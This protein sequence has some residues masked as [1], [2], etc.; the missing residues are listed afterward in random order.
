MITKTLEKKLDDEE[1][2]E[3]QSCEVFKQILEDLNYYNDDT[4]TGNSNQDS[5]QKH[6]DT[7][8]VGEHDQTSIGNGNL[9]SLLR[10]LNQRT[11]LLRKEL[12]I[13]CQIGR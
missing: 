3:E 10:E 6:G 8:T 13:K 5:T 9:S 12:K 1:R 11:S 2:S 4:T 7:I